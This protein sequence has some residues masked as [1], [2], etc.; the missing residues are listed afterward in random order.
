VTLRLVGAAAAFSGTS[1]FPFAAEENAGVGITVG[2]QFEV[3]IDCYQNSNGTG[4][5]VYGGSTFVTI[6]AD[7]TYTANQTLTQGPQS[8]NLALTANPNPATSGQSVT[9]TATASVSGATGTVTFQNNGTVI[10]SP[11]A[12]S[13]GT[14]ST[15]FTAPTVTTASTVNLTATYTPSGSFTAGTGGTLALPVNP[16][17]ANSGTIPLAVAV[18][19]AGSFTLTV[20]S[21][22]LVTLNATG[23]TATGATTPITVV[24][25]RNS[26]PGWS[27]SGQD[28]AWTGTGTAA[29]GTFSGNQLGWTP[30]DTALAQGATLG[31]PV[32]AGSPGLGSAAPLAS[33]PHGL[34]N[35]FGTT[36]LGANLS[37]A[38][39]ATAPAGPY[40]SGLTITAVTSN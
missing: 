20:D 26:Y 34:G 30:T 13:G 40:T 28:G 25:S 12:L 23:L 29:G 22:D 1:N 4:T 24:D 18:P 10:G 39:P 6:N 31:S 11:V 15:P 32:T 36:T 9:L 33:A 3:A 5:Q 37:L 21:T 7:G 17:P 38:I 27:V 8:V 14:A 16:A 19:Q 35:G 2:Q